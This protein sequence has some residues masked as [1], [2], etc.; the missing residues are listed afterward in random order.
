MTVAKTRLP[1]REDSVLLLPS[2]QTPLASRPETTT[3]ARDVRKG[4]WGDGLAA[5]L[6]FFS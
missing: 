6:C 1:G 3:T 2:L 4:D 5:I